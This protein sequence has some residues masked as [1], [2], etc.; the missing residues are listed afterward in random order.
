MKYSD[1]LKEYVKTI[2]DLV[3]ISLEDEFPIVV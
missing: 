1:I 3:D 2:R